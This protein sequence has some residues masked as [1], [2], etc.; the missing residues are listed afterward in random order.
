MMYGTNQHS[1]IL[2]RS[3]NQGYSYSSTL[4]CFSQKLVFAD[5]KPKTYSKSMYKKDKLFY[6]SSVLF[7]L[8]HKGE[9]HM[10]NL[11]IQLTFTWE[12]GITEYTK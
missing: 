7:F 11:E 8:S 4:Q 5:L 10:R 1:L 3:S 2:D 6:R 9:P 12:E